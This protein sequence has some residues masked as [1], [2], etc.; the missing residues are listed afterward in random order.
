MCEWLD[1][2]IPGDRGRVDASETG[3]HLFK[4]G[5][6]PFGLGLGAAA[7]VAR[8][9]TEKEVE[10]ELDSVCLRRKETGLALDAKGAGCFGVTKKT[11]NGQDVV[12]PPISDSEGYEAKNERSNWDTKSHH[13]RPDTHELCA[14]FLEK[15]FNDDTGADGSGWAD[16]KGG[17]CSAQGHGSVRMAVC[18]A[19]V[20]NQTADQRDQE[21]GSSAI[22]LGKGPPQQRCNSQDAN[23][24]GCQVTC[25]LDGNV[26][27]L[28]NV[29]KGRHDGGSS[30]G[31]HHGVEGHQDQIY[32][33]LFIT[34]V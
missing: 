29:D 11:Y 13:D 34:L 2:V 18:A 15:C 19:D 33:F 23:H 31:A 12:Y 22:T 25:C 8:L 28:C 21:D 9:G 26:Q 5:L 1:K 27:V 32:D 17:D 6:V 16:E 30:E 3:V 10:D 20:A 7:D 14:V 4:V 24:L